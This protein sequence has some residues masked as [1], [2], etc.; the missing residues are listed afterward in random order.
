MN[1]ED[2]QFLIVLF[3]ILAAFGAGMIIGGAI[4]DRAEQQCYQ[5]SR[6]ELPEPRG[7]TP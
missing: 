7:I 6:G 5:I 3:C 4:D 1:R 2:F